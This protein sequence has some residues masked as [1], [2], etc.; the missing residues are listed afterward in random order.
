M[1]ERYEEAVAAGAR[2]IPK[3]KMGK[4]QAQWKEWCERAE[5]GAEGEGEGLKMKWDI[6]RGGYVLTGGKNGGRGRKEA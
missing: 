3:D 5:I 6:D 2:P 1:K 4:K